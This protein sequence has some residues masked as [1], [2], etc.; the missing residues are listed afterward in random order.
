MKGPEPPHT[1]L[2]LQ[3]LATL[4]ARLL[5][6]TDNKTYTACEL[7]IE[8]RVRQAAHNK[9]RDDSLDEI[10]WLLGEYIQGFFR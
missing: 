5:Y 9:L 3:P 6:V 10:T 7:V 4:K 1:T 2:G 8:Q